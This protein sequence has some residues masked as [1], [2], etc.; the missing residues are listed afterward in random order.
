[1]FLGGPCRVPESH[2]WDEWFMATIKILQSPT[3]MGYSITW[4]IPEPLKS[5]NP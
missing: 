5:V 4:I 3:V 2:L 1:M